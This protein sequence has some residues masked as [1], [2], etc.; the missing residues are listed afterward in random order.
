MA[1]EIGRRLLT[2]V[3]YHQM[4]D[5]GI[6]KEEG[7][8][9]INGEIIKMSPVGS[10]HA[11]IVEKLK[12]L[13]T[14]GLFQKAIIRIQNPVCLS[15]YSEPEPDLAIVKYRE[16]YYKVAHP[17]PADVLVLIEVAV[18]SIE[19]DKE[20]KLPLYAKSQIPE[21][22]LINVEKRQIEVH[23]IPAEDDYKVRKIYKADDVLS[24][25]GFDLDIPIDNI[26]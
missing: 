15:E 2:V 24:L 10:H 25:T 21:F 18:S 16:D 12:D 11:S 7:L 20:V 1:I 5:A 4:G 26:F 22:W 23:T 6:L 9:L 13:L 14:I 17:K 8:E 19:Y 3:E